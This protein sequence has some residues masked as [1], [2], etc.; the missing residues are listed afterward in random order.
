MNS[1]HNLSYTICSLVLYMIY[2]PSHLKYASA[3]IRS[4]DVGEVQRIKTDIKSDHWRL[5]ITLSWVVFVHMYAFIL[6]GVQYI[7]DVL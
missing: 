6:S 4:P 3:E 2:Y 5:S 7:I 1:V